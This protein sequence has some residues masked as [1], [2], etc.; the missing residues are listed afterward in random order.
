VATGKLIHPHL[1]A[2]ILDTVLNLVADR[3]IE[4]L[5]RYMNDRSMI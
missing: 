4:N 5:R 3:Y 1:V 2:G